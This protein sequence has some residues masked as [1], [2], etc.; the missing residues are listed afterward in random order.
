MGEGGAGFFKAAELGVWAGMQNGRSK[1]HKLPHHTTVTLPPLLII[2]FMPGRQY[3]HAFMRQCGASS[4][5]GMI[6]TCG[7]RSLCQE[8]YAVAHPPDLDVIENYA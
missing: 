7:S 6:R 1:L 5:A 8:G 4:E 2:F 3:M